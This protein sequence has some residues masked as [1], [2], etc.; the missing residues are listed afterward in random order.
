MVVVTLL[1]SRT[2]MGVPTVTKLVL[3][4]NAVLMLPVVS[5]RFTAPLALLAL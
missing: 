3:I 5:P 2:T 1:L 4:D